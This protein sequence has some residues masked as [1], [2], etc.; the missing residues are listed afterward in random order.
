MVQV[1]ISNETGLHARPAASFCMEAKK[2]ESD[3][4]VIKGASSFN[5]KS[6][7]SVMSAS[8]GCGDIIVI[9]ATGD[10]AGAA[11]KELSEF[12]ATLEG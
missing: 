7:I 12:L 8:I 3:I 5:A 9:E 4:K 10:D 2:Y 11:E 6:V 1:T